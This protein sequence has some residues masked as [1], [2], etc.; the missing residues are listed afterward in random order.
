MNATRHL[1]WRPIS[2]A[3]DGQKVP[4]WD[5]DRGGFGTGRVRH[6]S[7]GGYEVESDDPQVV[8]PS[9]YAT[10]EGP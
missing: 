7:S 3:P 6:S 2:Q 8:F 5:K 9:H 1:N 4:L 10:V